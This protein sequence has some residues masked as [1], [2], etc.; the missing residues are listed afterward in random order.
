MN[1]VVFN[2]VL[3]FVL[4]I[5][6]SLLQSRF[7]IAKD[8]PVSFTL[9]VLIIPVLVFVKAAAKGINTWTA[10]T[11]LE[12]FIYTVMISYLNIK[13]V[14]PKIN[15]G[16]IYAYTLLHWYFL[17][18]NIS[19]IGF[20]FWII[21]VL[22]ISAYPTLLLVKNLFL[23]KRLNTIDKAILF[24]WFIITVTFTY[25]DQVALHI[26]EPVLTVDEISITSVFIMLFS[27]IQLYFIS[28]VFT[29]LFLGIPLFHGGRGDSWAVKM[30]EW[31]DVLKHKLNS[32]VEY[33]VS[34]QIV[35]F[36]TV[37]SVLLFYLDFQYNLRAELMCLYTILFP[38]V[39]F[40]LKASP[41]DNIED[42]VTDLDD[43]YHVK[44][45]VENDK[46]G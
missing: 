9:L 25:I 28:M 34:P 33:Q 20:N 1:P 19:A 17:I 7:R 27:A 40:Y 4:V 29:W 15:E 8:N 38:I 6:M 2:C 22:A 30:K 35:V 12:I 10:I 32:Y 41:N 13:R 24:Y 43:L 11:G 37:I 3:L 45:E 5:F 39:F 26:I 36:I 18:E 16:Y 21:S 44:E 14:L 31:K 42:G 23:H 46:A